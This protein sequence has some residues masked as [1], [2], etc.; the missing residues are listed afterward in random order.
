VPI[1]I[2]G[3]VAAMVVLAKVPAEPDKPFDFIGFFCIAGSLFS[4]LLALEEGSSWGWTSYP[5]L[6]CSCRDNLLALSWWSSCRSST[7]C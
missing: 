2:L 3:A 7:R 6:I 1:G 5:V 4:L